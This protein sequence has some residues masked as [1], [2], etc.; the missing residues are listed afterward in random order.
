MEWYTHSVVV[1]V[2]CVQRQD[3]RSLQNPTQHVNGHPAQPNTLTV[4]MLWYNP[5]HVNRHSDPAQP[6]MSSHSD[7]AQ[8]S[9]CQQWSCTTQHV[10]SHSD[11]TQPSTCQHSDPAQPT[12]TC[13]QS[14]WFYTTP[15]TCQQPQWSFTTQQVNSHNDLS[16]HINSHND[17]SQPHMSTV[18]MILHN[19]LHVNSHNNPSQANMSTIT[20]ILHNPAQHAHTFVLEVMQKM[21]K[22]VL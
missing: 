19:P 5:A 22:E 10:N 13:Q 11:S 15:K 1:D 4:T 2:F 3:K 12:T 9:T 17:P 18:T 8:P 20:I 6:N 14:L 21:L 16:Q 7:P